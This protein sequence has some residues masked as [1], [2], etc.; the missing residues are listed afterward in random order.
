MITLVGLLGQIC[1]AVCP[2]FRSSAGSFHIG[3]QFGYR[4]D[5]E[6]G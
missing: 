2:G 3:G 6:L 4:S 5:Q 1:N